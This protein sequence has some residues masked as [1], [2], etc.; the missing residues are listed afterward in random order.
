MQEYNCISLCKK[1]SVTAVSS[2]NVSC[3][4]HNVIAIYI[5]ISTVY[6]DFGLRRGIGDVGSS[7]GQK[8]GVIA[9]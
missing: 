2:L 4:K 6:S 7:D 1:I 3:N 5:Y 8:S 9:C